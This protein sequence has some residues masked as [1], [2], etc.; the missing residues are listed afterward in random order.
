LRALSRA[1]IFGSAKE[2]RF[3]SKPWFGWLTTAPKGDLQ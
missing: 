2:L 1:L 3:A